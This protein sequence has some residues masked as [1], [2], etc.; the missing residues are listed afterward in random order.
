MSAVQ[1]EAHTLPQGPHEDRLGCFPWCANVLTWLLL[2]INFFFNGSHA[3]LIHIY[4]EGILQCKLSL[5]RVPRNIDIHKSIHTE[6]ACRLNR[7]GIHLVES[8][9]NNC[10]IKRKKAELE[11]SLGTLQSSD[12]P[13]LALPTA[14]ADPGEVG[15]ISVLVP[16][17]Q[18]YFTSRDPEG[19][20]RILAHI[21]LKRPSWYIWDTLALPVTHRCLLLPDGWLSTAGV[22]VEGGVLHQG[23]KD[24]QEAHG[25]KE[26]H[27]GDVG[28]P[29]KGLPGNGA[30]RGHSEH[31]GDACR[32]DSC[33]HQGTVHQ[34]RRPKATQS[35]KHIDFWT[36]TPSAVP[37]R[38]YMVVA[39]PRQHLIVA[40]QAEQ[41][42]QGRQEGS[43]QHHSGQ[44]E[45]ESQEGRHLRS[46][47]RPHFWCVT[48]PRYNPTSTN[49]CKTDFPYSLLVSH[50][51]FSALSDRDA[52]SNF[53]GC[54]MPLCTPGFLPAHYVNPC[55]SVL[56]PSITLRCPLWKHAWTSFHTGLPTQNLSAVIGEP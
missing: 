50:F 35:K 36:L 10:K 19:R 44:D 46:I 23:G 37:G 24:K 39:A 31:C 15:G 53:P 32:E 14:G 26:V 20:N 18:F 7:S 48:G 43:N 47:S 9:F 1:P 49:T 21:S 17:P 40:E 52:A 54:P 38:W 41:C 5:A 29:R 25:D 3:A 8:G 56:S 34:T 6:G 30:E 16:H 42:D 12:K 22:V 51:T 11:S 45:S 55:P 27:G 33:Q 4:E 28:D 2:V 13:T